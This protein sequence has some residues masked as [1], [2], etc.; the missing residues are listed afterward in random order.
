MR[1]LD[2]KMKT[3]RKRGIGEEDRMHINFGLIIQKYETYK[4]LDCVFW[5]YVASGEYRKPTTAAMLKKKGLKA[6][7][8]DYFFIKRDKNLIDHL[9]WIEFKT[10]KGTQQENQKEFE[11]VFE[12]AKN[13]QYYLARSVEE[14]LKILEQEGVLLT[15]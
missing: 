5:S 2:I 13:S 7:Q 14:G 12:V 3:A 1:G 11:K 15:K 8:A 10:Q 4:K 9:I 6:G